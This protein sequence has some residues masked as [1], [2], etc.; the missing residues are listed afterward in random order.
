V[1]GIRTRPPNDSQ[2]RKGGLPPPDCELE[3][4][5]GQATLPDLRGIWSCADEFRPA[6]HADMNL[7]SIRSHRRLDPARR[8]DKTLS[9]QLKRQQGPEQ[10]AMIRNAA[11]V[12]VQ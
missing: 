9:P 1:Y 7:D 11:F 10:L 5:R 8:F 6:P 2:V 4:P 12:L 3:E